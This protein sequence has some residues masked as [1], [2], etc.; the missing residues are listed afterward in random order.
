MEG[1]NRE[2]DRQPDSGSSRRR[3]PMGRIVHESH[4]K[5]KNMRICPSQEIMSTS[6]TLPISFCSTEKF[7]LYSHRRLS[8]IAA[9]LSLEVLICK[10]KVQ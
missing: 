3:L 2:T 5:R 6:A 1:E 8:S 4:A 9:F 10:M 7:K